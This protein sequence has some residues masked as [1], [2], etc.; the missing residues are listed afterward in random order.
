MESEFGLSGWVPCVHICSWMVAGGL[1]G[2][3]PCVNMQ[4]V[5]KCMYRCLCA[6][7]QEG[8]RDMGDCWDCRAEA[9]GGL[10]FPVKGPPE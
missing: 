1:L 7:K 9:L 2:V 4:A 8:V 5:W 10:S 3:N 6:D